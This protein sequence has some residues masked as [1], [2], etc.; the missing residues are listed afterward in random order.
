MT[1]WSTIFALCTALCLA[2]SQLN[3][4]NGSDTFHQ[5]FYG[6]VPIAAT[7]MQVRVNLP[8]SETL[9]RVNVTLLDAE[10]SVLVDSM[11]EGL[12]ASTYGTQVR[13]DTT[14]PGR[15]LFLLDAGATVSAMAWELVLGSI[16][17]YNFE[18][19]PSWQVR[20]VLFEAVTSANTL[21]TAESTIS[22]GLVSSF[23]AKVAPVD[24][25][26]LLDSSS[27]LGVDGWQNVL[28]FASSISNA[29][30]LQGGMH[31]YPYQPILL[32]CKCVKFCFLVYPTEYESVSGVIVD[33]PL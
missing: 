29:L 30:I 11:N 32:I 4:G 8:A 5:T 14:S 19:T 3:I 20:Y 6:G 13:L 9:V 16:S 10:G 18:D 17:F 15:L 21:L 12:S 23:C 22:N 1:T 24:L 7:S 31:R 26:L 27:S 33:W 28:Q 25:V 2:A